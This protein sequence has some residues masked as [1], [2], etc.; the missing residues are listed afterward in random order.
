MLATVRY[1]D[2]WGNRTCGIDHRPPPWIDAL[3]EVCGIVSPREGGLDTVNSIE[4]MH[5]GRV[6]V[7][8]GMGGN[9]VRATPDSVVTE[10]ALA[11]VDLTVQVSTKLNGSHAFTGRQIGRAHV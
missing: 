1:G 10:E 3:D 6:K 9:F 7:F 11:T 2:N 8:V 5:D 4:G